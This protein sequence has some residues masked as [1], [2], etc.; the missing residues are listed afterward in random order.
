MNCWPASAKFAL[1]KNGFTRKSVIFL[2]QA[3]LQVKE[4]KQLTL[5][6]W[7]QNVDRLLEFND[8]PILSGSGKISTEQMKQIA[9]DRY[10]AFDE[11]RRKAEA[12]AARSKQ[13]QPSN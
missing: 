11:S 13:G 10:D 8:K 12:I 2:E 9:H 1:R 6:F 7:R 3:E 5:D 4:R